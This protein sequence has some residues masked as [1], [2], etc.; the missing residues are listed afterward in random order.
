ML[1][2]YRVLIDQEE[3]IPQQRPCAA[4]EYYRPSQAVPQLHGRQFQFSDLAIT[5]HNFYW[6]N[7][8]SLSESILKIAYSWKSVAIPILS[9]MSDPGF[10]LRSFSERKMIGERIVING[11]HPIDSWLF[12]TIVLEGKG[13]STS[14]PMRTINKFKTNGESELGKWFTVLSWR[15]LSWNLSKHS[16]RV[17]A[18]FRGRDLLVHPVDKD[19]KILVAILQQNYGGSRRLEGLPNML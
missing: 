17:L 18:A 4:R 6:W 13:T 12:Q 8:P 10:N 14:Q 11:H 3:S 16:V 1:A 7:H 9:S 2:K 15:T 5:L 19:G